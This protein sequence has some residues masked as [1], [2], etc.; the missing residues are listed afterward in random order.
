[1]NLSEIQSR[2]HRTA[3][4]VGWHDKPLNIEAALLL[5]HSEVSEATEEYRKPDLDVRT[6]YTGADGKPE[7]FGVE[8]ADI[9]IRTAELAARAG[10]D[11]EHEVA[12]KLAY[13][14]TR[15][16]RHGGKRI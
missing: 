13:N 7:G 4:A 12:A 5:I 6:S 15:P 3:Q 10:I 16:Y 2:A 9:I 11:L 8:L 14:E 1:M